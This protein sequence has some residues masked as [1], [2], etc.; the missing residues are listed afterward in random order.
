[1]ELGTLLVETVKCALDHLVELELDNHR[2]LS[3]VISSEA[4]LGYTYYYQEA[5]EAIR[6]VLVRLWHTDI[7]HYLSHPLVR[8]L[9]SKLSSIVTYLND[10]A[11]PNVFNL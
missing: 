8:A 5:E 9:Q 11:H 2:P 7:P 10:Y 4:A 3:M 6:L 1:M